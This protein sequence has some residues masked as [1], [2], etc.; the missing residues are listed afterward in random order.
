M[1]ELN[2]KFFRPLLSLLSVGA[3]L[4]V[5]YASLVPLNY[6]PLPWPETVAR[7]ENIPWIQHGI[8][9]RADWVANGLIMLPAGFLAAA[10][11]DWKNT[12]RWPLLLAAPLIISVLIAIVVGIEFVQP[13]FPPRVFSQNDILAGVIGSVASVVLWAI[14][15]SRLLDGLER[16]WQ[17]EAGWPRW[18][19]LIEYSMFAMLLYNLMPLDVMVS[20]EEFQVKHQ[21]RPF[22]L[23][24]FADFHWDKKTIANAVVDLVRLM[25]FAFFTAISYGAG[26]AVGMGFVWAVSLELVKIPIHSRVFSVTDIILAILGV[27]LA[28]L[29]APA[30]LR[31]SRK[32][33]L[34]GSWFLAAVGWSGIMLVGFLSRFEYIVRDPQLIQE[35]LRG[36]LHVPFARA[37]SSSEM[38]AGEN[39]L[40]KIMIFAALTFLLSGWCS[41][42]TAGL[43]KP[44]II[45]S[46]LWFLI[47]SAAIEV[48]QVFLYPLV[49]DV[50]DFI[51]YTMGAI[52]GIAAFKLMMPKNKVAV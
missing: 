47:L 16:I 48:G 30:L 14:C 41:R 19:L 9:R 33:D 49:P 8:D 51:I 43:H 22:T 52:C 26:R 5:V 27:A 1:R 46:T 23:I 12:R 28:T 7:F 20:A 39:I 10:A 4:F 32:L 2:P 36:I 25:P 3:A 24:P 18:Q 6:T 17:S 34:A 21:T 13:W 44:A 15:G 42:I 31:V 11:I 45:V 35:R 37:H 40:V 50:T 38:E 29:L